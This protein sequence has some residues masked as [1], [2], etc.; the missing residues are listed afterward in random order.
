MHPVP[1]LLNKVLVT[2]LGIPSEAVGTL[3]LC[4]TVDGVVQ[5]E[6]IEIDVAPQHVHQVVTADRKE[7]AVAADDPDV[8]IGIGELDAR[9][10]RFSRGSKPRPS[11]RNSK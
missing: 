7:V 5:Q 9:C 4:Q 8:E 3:S 10:Q 6:Q 11:A 2:S 1:E